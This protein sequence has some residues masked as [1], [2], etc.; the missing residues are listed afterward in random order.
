MPLNNVVSPFIDDGKQRCDVGKHAINVVL[1]SFHVGKQGS[2]VYL[3][4]GDVGKQATHVVL[5]ALNDGKQCFDVYLSAGVVGK[6]AANVVLHALNDGKQRCL[7]SSTIVHAQRSKNGS[8]KITFI[9][10]L[11]LLTLFYLHKWISNN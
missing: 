5:H 6:H 2:D 11:Y 7:V 10:Y 3:N 1:H 8:Y 4:A 9:I